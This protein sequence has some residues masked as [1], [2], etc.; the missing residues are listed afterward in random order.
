MKTLSI[1]CGVD[2]NDYPDED[3]IDIFDFGQKYVWDLEKTPWP[4]EG[5]SY[6]RIKAY[7]VLEHIHQDYVIAVMNECHRI[8]VPNGTFDIR[9]PPANSINE[10]WS[11]PTHHSHWTLKTFTKYF[12]G[13]SPRNADYGIVKWVSKILDDS[14]P[15]ELHIVLST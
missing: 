3:G 5:K 6:E 1:G 2:W 12:C 11:D 15:G 9:V 10:A 14:D 8:L 4:I 13:K 7:N